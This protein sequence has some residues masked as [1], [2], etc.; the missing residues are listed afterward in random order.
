[1]IATG[2]DGQQR[3]VA[4]Y[5]SRAQAKTMIER[6]RAMAAALVW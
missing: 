5:M 1:V 2:D 6:L 4:G 3:F